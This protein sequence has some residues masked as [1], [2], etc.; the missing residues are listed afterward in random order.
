[1]SSRRTWL[2]RGLAA[3]MMIGLCAGT[4]WAW[5]WL[6]QQRASLQA[7]ELSLQKL[8]EAAA[9]GDAVASEL[10][11]RRFDIQRVQSFLVTKD[12]VG[13]VVAEIEAAGTA[14]NVE[15][16]VPA[17]EEKQQFNAEGQPVAATGP[18]Y[19]VRL[20]VVATGKPAQLLA[21]LHVIEHLQRL[22]YLESFR[23]DGSLE[24]A[25]NQARALRRGEVPA[26]ERPALLTVDLVVAVL[27]EVPEGVGI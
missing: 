9:R 6:L 3:V 17:V 26:G 13:A 27:R 2:T 1:M 14:M 22:V 10:N 20:K 25:Q 16:N 7:Q 11:K 23:L 8:P 15:V 4:V 18:L 12:Q 21:F 5:N 24:T 19:E